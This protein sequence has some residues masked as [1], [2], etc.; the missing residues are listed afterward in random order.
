MPKNLHENYIEKNKLM[1]KGWQKKDL[2][3][4]KRT[5][6]GKILKKIP[7]AT[8]TSPNFKNIFTW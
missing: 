2:M 7:K 5:S 8:W 6:L 3:K 4:Q 1:L